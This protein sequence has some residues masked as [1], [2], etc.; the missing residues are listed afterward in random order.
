MN[1]VPKASLPQPIRT[2]ITKQ[3]DL[4]DRLI[5]AGPY[6]FDFD[7]NELGDLFDDSAAVRDSHS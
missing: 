6:E 7:P 2:H 4:L 3:S 1:N 5:E